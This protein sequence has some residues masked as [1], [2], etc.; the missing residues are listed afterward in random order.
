MNTPISV[1]IHKFTSCDGCQLAFL[2][3]GEQLLALVQRIHI[4]HFAEMGPI[5]P[6]AKVDISFVEGSISTAEEIER[7]QTIR[8]NSRLLITIGAC[9]TSGGLQ[10][11]RN[12]YDDGG[13]LSSVYASPQ[14]IQSLALVKPVADLVR[15]DFELW[16]C[17][18]DRAQL[19]YVINDLLLG[20]TP[21]ERR[22]NL[23]VTCKGEQQVCHL[24]AHGQPCLGPVTRAGCGALCPRFG[25]GCYGCYG[26]APSINSTA[27]ANRLQG[28]GLVPEQI[29]RLF[30]GIHNNAE[31]FRQTGLTARQQDK[32]P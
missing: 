21:R 31:P 11:L 14:H 3:L 15:V 24:V 8:D 29:A 10:A 17:P 30:H 9:A 23:C 32:T 22:D 2:N 1:A 5:N 7:I 26:P 6:H 20:V 18:I 19:L 27:L 16:G 25:R 4:A 13:W 12:L 28:L